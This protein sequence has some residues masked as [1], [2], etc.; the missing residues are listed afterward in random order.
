MLKSIVPT[1]I[2]GVIPARFASSRFPGKAL[3]I[4]AG[5]PM[6]QHVYERASRSRYLSDLLIATDSDQIAAASRRFGAT[7][8]MTRA[9]H[10]SGTDRVAE[11]ASSNPA[12]YI[13]NIQGDEPLID[14][15]AID[16]AI[17]SVL[18]DPD[19]SMGTLMKKIENPEDIP[20]PNIVKVV[21][22]LRGRAIYF[23]RLPI[24]Y[25]REEQDPEFPTRF[26]HIGLYVYRRDLLLSYPDLPVGPLE[27]AE[28]LEQLRAIE[29]GYSIRLVETDYESLGVDTP[30][31]L[32]RVS[33]FYE[34]S[35]L[36]HG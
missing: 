18:G 1:R 30:D 35:L 11:V 8:R 27:Q 34:A 12:E 6:I 14:P 4:I 23:S 16:A 13:V 2:L 25:R 9:D 24:P 36:F 15:D 28:R 19:V 22:D 3:A 5:K 21:P 20:N 31:D 33:S 17:L 10:L 32:Q 7:V 26:K 29:N